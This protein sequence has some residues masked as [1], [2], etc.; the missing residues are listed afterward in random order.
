MFWLSTFSKSLTSTSLNLWSTL[1]INNQR[2]QLSRIDLDCPELMGQS[3]IIQNSR[4]D[5]ILL[6]IVQNLS[7]I[8]IL[9]D[10]YSIFLRIIHL[11]R[12][13]FDILINL[14]GRNFFQNYIKSVNFNK[15]N[16]SYIFHI[17]SNKS[18]EKS[19]SGLAKLIQK[20]NFHHLLS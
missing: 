1:V 12:Y 6:K 19:K 7:G 16:K 2:D 18:I 9:I 3:R 8:D 4:I 20:W 17:F 11:I 5:L 13:L 15:I 10:I 14:V